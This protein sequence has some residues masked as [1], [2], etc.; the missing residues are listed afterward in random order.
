MPNKHYMLFIKDR[1]N[2]LFFL[3]QLA[4]ICQIWY[5]NPVQC[6]SNNSITHMFMHVHIVV[7]DMF[8]CVHIVV[9]DVYFESNRSEIH[10]LSWECDEKVPCAKCLKWLLILQQLKN[11]ESWSALLWLWNIN[12][13]FLDL[14]SNMHSNM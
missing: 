4:I 7:T 11:L 9:L 5:V 13:F 10:I 1:T 8:V 14:N 6:D 2:I 12:F 3:L